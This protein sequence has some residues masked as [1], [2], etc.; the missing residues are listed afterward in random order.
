MPLSLQAPP[1]PDE[2]QK[3]LD[4]ETYPDVFR[5][6]FDSAQSYNDYWFQLSSNAGFL[7]TDGM[8]VKRVPWYQY[9]W[10]RLKGW[11]GYTDHCDA[12]RIGVSLQKILYFGYIHQLNG[13]ISLS[14]RLQLKLPKQYFTQSKEPLSN[15]NSDLL[16]RSLVDSYQKMGSSPRYFGQSYI[17]A[18]TPACP[19]W[20]EIGTYLSEIVPQT[21]FDEK[22]QNLSVDKYYELS[23]IAS[24]KCNE[25]HKVLMYRITAQSN[26]TSANFFSRVADSIMASYPDIAIKY[27]SKFLKYYWEKGDLTQIH[28]LRAF[29]DDP[30]EVDLMLSQYLLNANDET[31]RK[32]LESNS[33][34]LVTFFLNPIYQ[35]A[36]NNP[37]A[38]PSEAKFVLTYWPQLIGNEALEQFIRFALDDINKFAQNSALEEVERAQLKL[39]KMSVIMMLLNDLFDYHAGMALLDN[40]ALL[41]IKDNPALL[42]HLTPDTPVANQYAQR[43]LETSPKLTPTFIFEYEMY[44]TYKKIA[45]LSPAL[46]ITNASVAAVYFKSLLDQS[47]WKEA[48]DFYKKRTKADPTTT[49]YEG[50][51]RTLARE[52]GVDLNPEPNAIQPVDFNDDLQNEIEQYKLLLELSPPQSFVYQCAARY[53]LDLIQFVHDSYNL[54]KRIGEHYP[55]MIKERLSVLFK[56]YVHGLGD[57]DVIVELSNY[58]S[59]DTVRFDYFDQYI[60]NAYDDS[61]EPIEKLNDDMFDSWF[62]HLYEK[63]DSLNA[64]KLI[65]QYRK[66]DIET[67]KLEQYILVALEIPNI[68]L[69]I[70]LLTRLYDS[71]EEAALLL[72]DKYS[73]LSDNLIPDTPI[74]IAFAKKLHRQKLYTVQPVNIVWG[75][76]CSNKTFSAEIADKIIRLNTKSSADYD[77]NLA[78]YH[79]KNLL[80]ESKHSESKCCDAW[81]FYRDRCKNNPQ[82]VWD[83]KSL[84]ELAGQLELLATKMIDETSK[85]EDSDQVKAENYEIILRMLNDAKDIKSTSSRCKQLNNIAWLMLKIVLH[86]KNQHYHLSDKEH[87]SAIYCMT[88]IDENPFNNT[89]SPRIR[90]L[91]QKRIAHHEE[92]NAEDKAAADNQFFV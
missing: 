47:K 7:Y 35:T 82:C 30:N 27:L 12:K 69:A 23:T 74:A 37:V 13:N 33:T 36:K 2:P 41:L 72:L 25:L 40:P 84:E 38:S 55:E 8:L 89:E 10:E 45:Y 9:G 17:D 32:L 6:S 28:K 91:Y 49:W 31:V 80:T 56:L 48:W 51:L 29:I 90:E 57:L 1:L 26:T 77:D 66:H 60:L 22:L 42:D 71:N 65:L 75:L 79:L 85:S 58:L 5:Y 61:A 20:L 53:L 62:K 83:K 50:D 43:L 34:E 68:A 3:Q 11:L 73:K 54:V 76:F 78:Q 86:F 15:T 70:E 52:L 81:N 14:E 39:N 87:K 16:Q 4:I 92:D 88:L 64:K 24:Q 46:T 18:L 21:N 19:N 44:E 59:E 63:N 67:N